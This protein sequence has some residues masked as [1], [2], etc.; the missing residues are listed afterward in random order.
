MSTVKQHI[1]TDQHRKSAKSLTTDDSNTCTATTSVSQALLPQLVD[2]QEQ[3]E[4]ASDLCSL[5]VRT[6]I[7]IWKASYSEFR[8]FFKKWTSQK[9]PDEST[10]RKLYMP[11]EY[12]ASIKSM[13]Q[14][15]GDNFIWISIDESQDVESR[16]DSSFLIQK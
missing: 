6:G 10:L 5:L 4:F 16:Y 15:I 1:H 9:V 14:A 2:K 8:E 11:R 12:Q 7:P 13:R 3:Q